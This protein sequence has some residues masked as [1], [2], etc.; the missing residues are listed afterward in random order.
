M[1][2][3]AQRK[4]GSISLLHGLQNRALNRC[5]SSSI[6]C[7]VRSFLSSLSSCLV[8]LFS[9]SSLDPRTHTHARR[10]R[11]HSYSYSP[12]LL[13]NPPP[14]ANLAVISLSFWRNRGSSGEAL[15]KKASTSALYSFQSLSIS[16]SFS[17]PVASI[18]SKPF[19]NICSQMFARTLSMPCS[20]S[21][22][23]LIAS[24]V[25]PW[26]GLLTSFPSSLSSVI[27]GGSSTCQEQQK[28]KT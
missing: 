25:S 20:S 14:R 10:H 27:F 22:S 23:A 19:C 15:R 3:G 24:G 5:A 26:L 13:F 16:G 7:L 4:M 18:C 2:R 1:V 12:L 11:F 9:P 6:S 28:V 8:R 17:N 21:A